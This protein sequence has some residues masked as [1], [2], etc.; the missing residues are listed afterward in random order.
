MGIYLRNGFLIIMM[1]LLLACSADLSGD[2]Y[3]KE[4]KGYLA[5]GKN[6]AAII[7]L[8]NALQKNGNNQEARW[9]LGE[10]YFN[11]SQYANAVKE[12]A[13]ARELGWSGDDVLP[14]LSQSFLVQGEMDKLKELPIDGLSDT[15]K[16]YVLA[17]QGMGLLRTRGGSEAAAPLIDQ[18]IELSATAYALEIKA[19][20]I[21]FTSKGNWIA[22]RQQ[23]Q[24]VFDV[25]PNYAPAWSLLGDI[26]LRSLNTDMAEEA[27]TK[28]INNSYFRLDDYYKRALVRLQ[29]NN[30]DGAKEDI[31]VLLKR[32]PKSPGTHYLQGLLHLRNHDMKNA[33]SAFDLAQINEERYPMSLFY[34]ATAHYS[35][36]NFSLAEDYAYR[37]LAIAPN[38]VAGR[39]LLATMKLKTG[40]VAEAETLIRPIVDAN[41]EDINALNLLASALLKQDKV[42][43]GVAILARVVDLQPDSPEA[44]VRLG[45]GLMASGEVAGGMEHLDEALKLNPQFQQ[46]D[47][48]LISAFLRQGDYVQALAAVDQFEKK[49]PGT[50]IAHSLRG[51]VYM[52]AGQADEA[53]VA[54]EKALELSPGDPGVSQNL[55]FLAIKENDLGQAKNY[56]LAVLEHNE[57][58][59]PVLLK[60]AAL[61]EIQRDTAGMVNYLEQAIEA[62]P[63]EVQPKVM[64][65]RYYLNYGNPEQVPV[66]LNELESE[67]ANQPDVL[68]VVALSHLKQR[69]YH[70]AVAAFKKLVSLRDD[71]PQP[72]HH[73]ALAYMG[74]GK[75]SQAKSEF[76]QAVELSPAYLK[77]RIEL[78]RLLLQEKARAEA[79][80]SLLI[81]K[82]LA[83][84][85]PEVL[86]LD[87]A[88]ARLDGNQ[89]EAL[90]LS[91]AAFEIS[92]TTRNML[93]LSHQYWAMGDEDASKNTLS[94]WV[95][96]H[97]KDVLA[98]LELADMYLGKG[99]EGKAVEEY[100][101]VLDAQSDNMMALNNL[102]WL[103]RD[104]KPKQALKY[105]EQAVDQSQESPL[106]LDTLAVVLLKND[107]VVKAQRTIERALDKASKNPSIKYHSAMINAAAGDK[108]KAKKSLEALLSGKDEFPERKDAES[109]LK[110]L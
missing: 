80:E 65:A 88:R 22:V 8:K 89:N 40:D 97:P 94:D 23:L 71:A 106:A 46:A 44:Q 93:I 60:M 41:G 63:E 15:S 79:V 42:E 82:K 28:A 4:A 35:E 12:L 39:K 108:A 31:D 10:V 66:L 53:K 70:D 78:T 26:E 62:H 14:L 1:G 84:K 24:K 16:S 5:E 74:L 52:A 107:D 20:L 21:G 59:L 109:L 38:N 98:R 7:E 110:E 36:G 104:S 43:E 18:A 85:N 25:D 100:S 69:K 83:P 13:K 101:Q 30:G 95:K 87:A 75:K 68:N 47:A 57:N 76:K 34:L 3:V 6:K 91:K 81:L 37:F 103:L 64:L 58:H 92:P 49:N 67:A 90:D 61:S 32:A 9:L 48:L 33:V 55:A 27:F 29:M 72:H 102:A 45:A 105:A 51:E 56:Y 2:K 17:S 11:K 50:V 96:E 19:R 86:Q 73:M 77:P 54:L 99:D